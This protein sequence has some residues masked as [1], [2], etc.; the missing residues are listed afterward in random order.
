MRRRAPEASYLLGVPTGSK[1]QDP[2]SS[3]GDDAS[4]WVLGPARRCLC[5]PFAWKDAEAVGVARRGRGRRLHPCPFTSLHCFHRPPGLSLALGPGDDAR[6]GPRRVPRGEQLPPAHRA[7]GWRAS[8]GRCPRPPPRAPLLRVC[9]KG[10]ERPGL[11]GGAGPGSPAP[12]AALAQATTRLR[13]PGALSFR[14]LR[15]VRPQVTAPRSHP[16]SRARRC[17]GANPALDLLGS[18]SPGGGGGGCPGPCW[19]T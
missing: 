10:Q 17:R 6:G 12:P 18:P 8:A 13:Q 3:S 14:L 19:R 5:L 7:R 4:L 16:R 11:A 1:R 2:D 9:T 15:T